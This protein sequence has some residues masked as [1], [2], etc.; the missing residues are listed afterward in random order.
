MD[1]KSFLYGNSTRSDSYFTLRL[2]LIRALGFIY[3]V[4]SLIIYFQGKAL[5]GENGLLPIKEF[6]STQFFQLGA[7]DLFWDLPSLFYFVQG[8][9]WL[10]IL[11]AISLALALLL[12]LGYANVPIL[13]GLWLIQ[14]S[15]VNSGQLFY[16]F[17]WEMQILELTFLTA[18]M[19]PFFDPRI[20]LTSEKKPPAPPRIVIWAMRWMLFRLMLG[21]GLIKIRGDDCWTDL[22]CLIYHY[23]TQPNPNPLSYFFHAL[24]EWFQKFGVL[25]NHFL[26]LIVPFGFFGPKNIRRAAGVLTIVFQVTLIFSGNLAWLNWLTLIMCIPCFDDEFLEKIQNWFK[27]VPI[28]TK[29]P[30]NSVS[31][32]Q[33]GVTSLFFVLVLVLSYAPAVNLLSPNQAMNTSYDSWH[34]INSY[35]AFGSIGKARGQVIIEGTNES[36]PGKDTVWKPYEFKC[37]PGDL[38]RMPCW[39]SPYHYHLDWQIWFSGMRP[40]IQEVWL[41]R[42]AVRLLENDSEIVSQFEFNPFSSQPPKWIRMQLYHYQYADWD[43]WPTSWWK[44]TFINNYLMP[45]SLETPGVE[46]FRIRQKK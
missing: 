1:I 44:R 42:L 32:I 20:K 41:F 18:F 23:E 14:I 28:T 8:D 45:I 46:K 11:P 26:E 36:N 39:I 9:I 34:L 16:S 31:R 43:E 4:S 15:Y 5:W 17:G 24:P 40:E 7:W 22:T 6:I 29:T 19:V 12:I 35:G 30:E 25:M 2:Y 37:A 13:F 3:F 10:K 21:A 27:K 38:N 33:L